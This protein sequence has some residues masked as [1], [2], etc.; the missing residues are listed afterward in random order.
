MKNKIGELDAFV[1]DKPFETWFLNYAG[2]VCSEFLTEIR[3]HKRILGIRCPE[4]NRVLV[5]ARP[6][7]ARCFTQTKDWVKV[8]DTGSLLTYATAYKALPSYPA[9]PPIIYGVIQLEGAD[10]GFVHLLGEVMPKDVHIGMRL[11]AVFN[12][13]RKGDIRDIKYF[14]PVNQG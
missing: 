5:P 7:C 13:E 14:R 8:S 1:V 9:Q 10:T 12:D 6:T 3:D 11:K 2:S 4:C